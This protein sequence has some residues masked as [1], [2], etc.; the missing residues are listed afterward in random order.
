MRKL[1]STFTAAALVLGAGLG[2]TPA[3]AETQPP[4]SSEENISF[5]AAPIADPVIPPLITSPI[6]HIGVPVNALQALWT[7]PGLT[8]TNEW[9]VGGVTTQVTEAVYV[10]QPADAGKQL[11]FRTTASAAGVPSRS[12]D[13]APVTVQ[14]PPVAPAI[15]TV[16]ITG[17]PVVGGSLTATATDAT[18]P[19]A[20]FTYQWLREGAPIASATGA[21]HNPTADDF[22]KQLSVVATDLRSNTSRQS[23]PTTAV[24]A[25]TLVQQPV[26]ITGTAVV[27]GTL[28][29]A[30]AAWAPSGIALSYQWLR[31]GSAIAGATGKSYRPTAADY[32]KTVSVKVTGSLHGYTSAVK[33][34]A[35]T[36]AVAA[37]ALASQTP[38]I[39]GSAVIGKTL[40]AKTKAW[41]PGKVALSYQWLRSGKSI[42]GATKSTYKLTSSDAG[43]K[44]TVRITGKQ[45]GYTTKTTTSKSTGSVLRTL[46][47]APAPKISGTV[48]VGS[49]VTAS[50]GAWKPA[51]VALKYQWLRNGAAIKGATK[52][53]YKLTSTDGGKKISVRVTGAK[54]G[55]AAIAKTSAAKTVQRVLKTAKPRI[56]GTAQVGKT[57]TVSY[58]SWTSGTTL[59]TQWLRNG[60]AIKGAT[61]SSYK[62]TGSDAGKR[63]SVRV[64]GSKS[65]Y[66]S[67]SST[68]ASTAAVGYPQRTAPSGWNCPA[69]A[70]I[71]GNA[72]SMIY[73]VPGGA[74]Y[75]RTNPEECFAT[76][77]A[78]ERAGYRASMR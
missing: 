26:T 25:G 38:A 8:I 29:A 68:S 44:I 24:A 12:F 7:Q 54:S 58:G 32:G 50:A 40:S 55:Y 75:N 4:V 76:T 22:G 9:I 35:A 77:G 67:A 2:A 1:M 21:S 27:G 46:T 15:I 39:S 71:K 65:G 6:A 60:S 51:K 52:S 23:D 74:F 53:K 3:F 34:S 16:T 37:G 66:L 36:K 10:P 18:T 20:E 17:T 70:P 62:L 43:K 72:S 11:V 19:N 73:H 69:W 49:T 41:G 56:S 59:K 31:G 42:K 14:G 30:T 47:A 5:T 48:R 33:A 64:S 61:K 45:T 28:T 57:L 63:I 78:A 13:S